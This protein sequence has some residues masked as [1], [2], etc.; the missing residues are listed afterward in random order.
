MKQE[1]IAEKRVLIPPLFQVV[2]IFITSIT[3]ACMYGYRFYFF[4]SH[5]PVIKCETMSPQTFKDFG[6]Y[7]NEIGIGFQIGEFEEFDI[8]KNNI[9]FTGQ[10]WFSLIPGSISLDTLE[11]FSFARG[12]IIYKSSPYLFIASDK[13]FVIFN[14]R[15]KLSTYLNLID[16]P[17]DNHTICIQIEHPFTN[18][19]ELMFDPRLEDFKIQGDIKT[20]GWTVFDQRVKSGFLQ[21]FSEKDTYNGVGYYPTVF[22]YFDIIRY[23]YQYA[24]TIFLPL[25]LIFFVILFCFSVVDNSTSFSLAVGGLTTILAYRFVIASISPQVGYFMMTDYMFLLLLAGGVLIFFTHVNDVYY[26]NVISLNVKK[27]IVVLMHCMI[28]FLSWYLLYC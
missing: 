20:F 17:F 7:T 16:F 10:V 13:L 21:R 22:F 12:E 3:L 18:P 27:L 4:R 15:V 19:S 24:L 23:G 8:V 14:I 2:L 9:M 5:D 6:G 26:K 11:K 25:I 1:L 28:S